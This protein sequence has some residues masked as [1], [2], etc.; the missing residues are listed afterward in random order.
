M[1]FG[2][3]LWLRMTL[4][5][6]KMYFFLEV[7]HRMTLSD[8]KMYFFLEVWLRMTLSEKKVYFFLEVTP[9]DSDLCAS[10]RVSKLVRRKEANWWDALV[11]CI[12]DQP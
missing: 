5:E 6:K 7:W 2:R 1:E 8:K 12:A 3:N 11:G 10:Q 4:S 9:S